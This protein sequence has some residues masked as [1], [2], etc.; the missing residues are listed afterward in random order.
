MAD[1]LFSLGETA[2]EGLVEF[3]SVLDLRGVEEG[4]ARHIEK[5]VG[6]DVEAKDRG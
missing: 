1:T 6:R 2:F 4:L 3:S 5:N